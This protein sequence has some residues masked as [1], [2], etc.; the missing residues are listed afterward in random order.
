MLEKAH[1]ESS[2]GTA[3][4]QVIGA[5]PLAGILKGRLPMRAHFVSPGSAG[6]FSASTDA[7][8][9]RG[10]CHASDPRVIEEPQ[11]EEAN[12]PLDESGGEAQSVQALQESR[13]PKPIDA[14]DSS[15][16]EAGCT[17]ATLLPQDS[18]REALPEKKQ[19]CTVWQQES[20]AV[21]GGQASGPPGS[22][23][24]QDG[25]D[26]PSWVQRAANRVAGASLDKWLLGRVA[27]RQQMR[28]QAAA[29][30]DQK[31]KME[32]SSNKP[33]DLEHT[34]TTGSPEDRTAE[35]R[36]LSEHE[37]EKASTTIQKRTAPQS[38]DTR[39]LHQ[40]YSGGV[41]TSFVP[42]L[43]CVPKTKPN[44]SSSSDR[45]PE[46]KAVAI[47]LT[48]RCT[49]DSPD[50]AEREVEM[51]SGRANESRHQAQQA[52]ISKDAHPNSSAGSAALSV[53]E[54][55][56]AHG[57]NNKRCSPG[58]SPED[59]CGSADA[60]E[61]RPAS[62]GGLTSGLKF[63]AGTTRGWL[64]M[65]KDLES[66]GSSW[67]PDAAVGAGNSTRAQRAAGI[68]REAGSEVWRWGSCT[69]K[70]I[71]EFLSDFFM[72]DQL[73]DLFTSDTNVHEEKL[74]GDSIGTTAEAT[75]E[76]LDAP[77]EQAATVASDSLD[78]VPRLPPPPG[79]PP[80]SSPIRKPRKPSKGQYVAKKREWPS[81]DARLTEAS[82]EAPAIPGSLTGA[83]ERDSLAAERPA[84]D[85]S[86]FADVEAGEVP[87]HDAGDKDMSR[88]DSPTQSRSLIGRP[89]FANAF[90]AGKRHHRPYFIII[91]SFT[92]FM[93]WLVFAIAEGSKH[94]IEEPWFNLLAGLESAFPGQTD[95]RMYNDCEDFRL[96][97]WRWL[98]YQFTHIGIRHIAMNTLLA[99]L[100]GVQLECFHGTR[101]MIVMFNIGVF[102]GACCAFVNDVHMGVV[103]MSGGCYSLIGMNLADLVMN[104][105]QRRY[106]YQRLCFLA[107]IAGYD[108]ITTY[109]VQGGAARVS[110][111]AHFGGYIAGLLIAVVL[112]R[113]VV[114][115][116]WERKLQAIAFVC[117][118]ALVA[119]CVGWGQS[120]PP[121]TIWEPQGWCWTRQVFNKE[122][123]GPDGWY[124]VR[125]D[126][127]T[128]IEKW[129]Q[130]TH[131]APVSVWSCDARGGWAVTER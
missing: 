67:A 35:S 109:L 12:L 117:G 114:V 40:E 53:S 29:T 107:V 72:F 56:R 94:G 34:T 101:R 37:L 115:H 89:L 90:S 10:M 27:N 17:S 116:T 25:I 123:F 52:A 74:S 78:Q 41:A 97:V 111:S 42:E 71:P 38:A 23:S 99:V 118:L 62:A 87:T 75:A 57:T 32:K 86:A 76:V 51:A 36:F 18:S 59:R 77:A 105:A 31:E 44:E 55:S 103:G 124:C 81:A 91:Q 128:C 21:P 98:T 54:A 82:A 95:L 48:D 14:I 131:I 39:D 15:L 47:A 61:E 108:L 46:E 64:E 24:A 85:H 106:R 43:P 125:C 120:W 22:R 92:A 63:F 16:P 50:L 69:L 130:Q 88:E 19:V 2:A 11:L 13:Q 126:G 121:K 7:R 68:I 73:D 100:F 102:G 110:H 65:N 70:G 6:T 9:Q 119:F 49:A 8:R 66:T 5:N 84:E 122:L 113:N 80:K 79:A 60:Q 93:L 104:W 1:L 112:G 83:G 33:N 20:F 30:E 127:P 45:L 129:S 96:Q 58:T 26:S 3:A 4:G 28:T